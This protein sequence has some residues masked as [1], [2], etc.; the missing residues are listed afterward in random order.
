M[1]KL[2]FPHV[3]P[4]EPL[5]RQVGD[6][7]KVA[8]YCPE[9]MALGIKSLEK[10]AGKSYLLVNALGAGEKWGSN[11]NGDYFPEA[12]L[13][14]KS[15][16]HGYKTFELYAHVYQHHVNKDPA[17]AMGSVKVAAYNPVMHRVELLLE[18]D[19]VKAAGLLEKVAAGEFPDW[20]MGCKV[21]YDVCSNCGHQAKKVA[22]YCGHLKT[23]MNRIEDNGGRNYAVNTRPK[24]FDISEVVVGADKT[25]KLLRKVASAGHSSQLSSAMLGLRYYGEDDEKSAGPKIA[26]MDKEVPS[27][28]SQILPRLK[29]VVESLEGYEPCLPAST[30]EKLSS[31]PLEDVFSTL[32]FSGIVLRPSEFQSIVL[33]KLGKA[34]LAVALE[35]RGISLRPPGEE[36][37][38]WMEAAAD[39]EMVSPDNVKEAV[40]R[41]VKDFVPHRSVWEPH[42]HDRV[43]Q[44]SLMAR[45]PRKA[46]NYDW[47]KTA[48][49]DLLGLLTGLGL[50]YFLYRKSFPTQSSA[51]E[52]LIM[53]KPWM[54]PILLGGSMAAIS[55]AD[56]VLGA[57]PRGDAQRA[58]QTASVKVA[59]IPWKTLGMVVGPVGLAYI[60]SASAARKE[61]MGKELNTGEEILR[62]YP[63]LVGPGLSYGLFKATKALGPKIVKAVVN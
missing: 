45:G 60:G 63:G 17:K 34:D 54:A 41:V 24:F 23:A 43:K 55:V 7:S 49:P 47:A 57:T 52:K 61:M 36:D 31:H 13:M 58:L 12:A 30:V 37:V 53:S 5:V 27:E 10:K 26:V 6:F 51:F 50:S 29:K 62:D 56:A 2:I 35:K 44:A 21:P 3:F 28:S 32:G 46:P 4:N 22:E 40:F 25:A 42:I 59:N 48:A 20:S 18:V 1:Y 9:E 38:D 33:R 15:A 11:V 8:S 16:S 14:S 19:N 39:T